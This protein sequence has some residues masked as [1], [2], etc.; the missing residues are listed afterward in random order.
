M[1][2]QTISSDISHPD[3]YLRHG[4][5]RYSP[6]THSLQTIFSNISPSV[7]SFSAKSL[8]F[9]SDTPLRYSPQTY[10]SQTLFRHASSDA[11]YLYMSFSFTSTS[12]T[13]YL[14]MPFSFTSSFSHLTTLFTPSNNTHIKLDHI[15]LSCLPTPQDT[16]PL[17]Q[18][19]TLPHQV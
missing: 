18:F 17:N 2:P 4:P 12:D 16:W 15:L 1:F 7:T 13:F 8:S 5:L 14:Y 11:F 3:T 9:L 10:L 19:P 6:E